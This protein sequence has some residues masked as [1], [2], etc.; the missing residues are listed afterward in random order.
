[1][2]PLHLNP[3]ATSLPTV[4]L[5]VAAG[6]WLWCPG[7]YIKLSLAI[8]FT[9]VMLMFQCYSLKSRPLLLPLSPKVSS[10]CLPEWEC[11]TA[12]KR[13]E[14]LT[15]AAAQ[16]NPEDVVLSERNQTQQ[17][18]VAE[19]HFW[20]VPEFVRFAETEDTTAAARGC[21]GDGW[22]IRV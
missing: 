5:Q 19:S 15:R 14:V 8:C 7:S 22:R 9:W 3:P 12:M 6:H 21:W 4:F 10:L 18:S 17:D 11:Y 20:E 13:R 2:C 1:M 16:M